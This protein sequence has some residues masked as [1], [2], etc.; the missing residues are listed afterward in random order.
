MNKQELLTYVANDLKVNEDELMWSD[1]CI[2]PTAGFYH[3][4]ERN[5]HAPNKLGYWVL[6]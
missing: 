6:K 1:K 2:N 5:T 3:D 4:K